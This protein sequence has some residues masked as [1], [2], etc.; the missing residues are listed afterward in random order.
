[1]GLLLL[2]VNRE[3][4]SCP[5]ENHEKGDHHEGDP[6]IN[7]CVYVCATQRT[8]NM[9]NVIRHNVQRQNSVM[10]IQDSTVG[11]K[12]SRRTAHDL[13]LRPHHD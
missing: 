11:G 1:M 9:P 12:V 6:P 13:N 8:A 3:P 10:R 2:F 4:F 7:V 5:S